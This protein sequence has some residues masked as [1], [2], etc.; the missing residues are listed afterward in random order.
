MVKLNTLNT[1]NIEN[2]R[3]SI[4][5]AARND[6]P[7]ALAVSVENGETLDDI[8]DT[9]NMMTPMHVACIMRSE[10]FLD[11]AKNYD[12]DPWIR[13]IS[14]RLA[15]DHA[16]AQGL[17]PAQQMLLGRMYPSDLAPDTVVSLDEPN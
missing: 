4:F 3:S 11:A 12:F 17:K 1:D 13:D 10:K 14:D 6:D 8:E 16:R 15:I 9:G 7:A 2:K 5:D